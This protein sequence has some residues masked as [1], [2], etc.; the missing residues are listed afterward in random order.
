VSHGT[1]NKNLRQEQEINRG[2][3]NLQEQWN[4]TEQGKNMGT[5]INK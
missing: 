4:E 1:R 5:V 3:T 2:R